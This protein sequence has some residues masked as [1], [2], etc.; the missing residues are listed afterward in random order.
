[1]TNASEANP[2]QADIDNCVLVERHEG[3][4]EVIL[5]R[6]AQRNSVI[7]P[8]SDGVR[9]ALAELATDDTVAC[10]VL[11]GAGGFFCSGVDLRAL[12]A[13]PPPPWRAQQFSSWRDLHLALYHFPKPVIEDSK[14]KPHLPRISKYPNW[15][16]FASECLND[17]ISV[18]DGQCLNSH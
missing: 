7:P 12:Q 15:D 8:L 14:Y 10:V 3:W 18:E 5:N 11:R 6:P 13:D 9:L 2:A 4:A 16:F 1:M 17:K